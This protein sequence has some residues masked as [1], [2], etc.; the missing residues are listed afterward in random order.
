VHNATAR[1]SLLPLLNHRV[2]VYDIDAVNV[3]YFQRPVKVEA[4]KAKLEPYFVPVVFSK[5]K[6]AKILSYLSVDTDIKSH[7]GNLDLLNV[8]LHH[9]K[10][11]SIKGKG[12]LDG[13]VAFKKGILLPKT[14][15]NIHA[16]SLALAVQ[17]YRVKGDGEITLKIVSEK[18]KEVQVSVHFE[19]LQAFIA[20]D[21]NDTELFKGK[22]LMLEAK[23]SPQLFPIPPKEE[24][25]TSISMDIPSVT[26][27]NIAVFQRYVPAKWTFSLEEGSGELHAKA[28]LEKSH[29]IL[30]VQL[31]SK[32][33]KV[34][35]SKQTFKSDMDLVLK[36]DATSGKVF[37]ADMSGSYLTLKDSV[38][39]NEKKT[40]K[41][42]FKNWDTHLSIDKSTFTLP[43]DG[44]NN[45]SKEDLRSMDKVGIKKFLATSDAVLK[46]TGNISQFDWLNML[47]NNS[48]NLTFAGQGKIE[49]DL[50]L[51]EGFLTKGSKISVVPE[52]LEV[53]LLDYMFKG[54]GLFLFTVT[55]GGEKPSL[56]FDLDLSD[57]QMN[58]RSEKQAM[59]EH[60]KIKLDGEV[61]G[62]DLKE[63]QKDIDLHLKIPSAKVKNIAVY[64][65][66]IPRNSPFKL[67]KGTAAISADIFLSSNNAKG[68]VKLKTDGLKMQVDDQK[69][70]ARLNINAKIAGGTPKNM[71]FNIAGSTIILD[72]AKVVGTTTTY[73]HPDW[74]AS[75]TLKKASVVWRKPIKLQSETTLKIKDSR[76]IVA[77]MDNKRDKNNWLSKLM[78]IENINGTATVNMQTNVITFPY[79]FVSSDKID[80]GAKGVISSAL[81]EG[82]FYFRY[83]KLKLLLKLKNGKKNID[84]FHV[85]NTFDRYKIPV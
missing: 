68:Y 16:D 45:I 37:K 64:N 57:T 36:F 12:M 14:D 48:L 67:T 40:K 13:H 65:S 21:R 18:A 17:E 75:I 78:T 6:G 24:I 26:V 61:T 15:V 60:V 33:A 79:A 76:P 8:Y 85:K 27:D 55:K 42:A 23:G 31:L 28:A 56:K 54:N 20:E 84:I 19:R 59:I 39:I 34:G 82:I 81:R 73:A 1:I 71:A 22:D 74:D 66:Y 83:K 7:M 52:D 32:E 77:I 10:E 72:Q 62:L 49:S 30:N 29:T 58:R 3:D 46:M 69:I 25:L 35:L 41:Q 51:K 44:E 63:D 5:N 70:S 47:L 38:I 50:T 80:I 4:K 2:K 53:G 9:L 11:T 43:L